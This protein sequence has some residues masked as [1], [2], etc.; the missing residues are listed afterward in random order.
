VAEE[1]DALLLLDVQIGYSTIAEE[2]EAIKPFLKRPYVHLAIDCE[3]NMA[4]GEIPGQTFG[5]CSGE[6]VMGA[7]D[8]LS[9]I[10]EENDL[11]PKVMVVHQFRSDMVINKE[12]LE[13]TEN[14]EMVVHADG[15]GLR[16]NKL[17]K[18][19]LLVNEQPVQYGGFKLFYDQDVNLF[20]PREVLKELDPDPAVISYQ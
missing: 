18:Y 1:N 17:S 6:N 11:P 5:Q 3:W 12:A 16:K 2:V 8:T 4:S 10:V 15:F 20:S 9:R 14:V 19:K 13:P 7:A